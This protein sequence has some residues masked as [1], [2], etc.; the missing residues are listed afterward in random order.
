M[1]ASALM[2]VGTRALVASQA[3]LQTTSHNISNAGVDGYSRQ[4]VLL[5]TTTGVYSGAGFIGRGVTVETVTRAVSSYL[6]D[7]AAHTSSVAS[8]DQ[9]T[10][11]L[12]GQLQDAFGTGEAGL[13]YATT[14]LLNAFSDLSTTPG[15]LSARQ[16]VLS[17]A[18]DLASLFS[19]TSDQVESLQRSVNDDVSSGAGT[20]NSL[21]KQVAALNDKIANFRGTGH[22]PNDLLDQRDQLISQ[23]SQYVEVSRLQQDD[24]AINLF[25]AGGQSLVLGNQSYTLSATPDPYDGSRVQLSIEVAG[26]VRNLDPD[27]LGGGSLASQLK[28]QRDDLASMRAQLGQLAATL[29]GAVNERQS[30]GLDLTGSTGGALF[31][32]GTSTT[33]PTMAMPASGNAKDSSGNFVGS[34]SLAV[35]DRT[36]LEASDYELRED[37]SAAG[38]YTLTRLSDGAVTTGVTDGSTVD[39]FTITFGSPG[40]QSGDKFLLKP[41]ST[42]ASLMAVNQSD[43]RSL[44]AANPVT[45]TASAS[46]RGTGAIASLTITAAPASSYQAMSLVFTSPSGDYELRDSG[47]A[48]LTSG[49]WSAARAITYDGIELTLNGAPASGDTFSIDP[50]ADVKTSN[51]NALAFVGLAQEA[52]VGDATFTDAFANMLSDLGVRVQSATAAAETSASTA[53]HVQ[54]SLSADTGVNLDEEAAKLIQYQQGYQAAAKILSVAQKVFD[55]LLSLGG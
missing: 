23:I 50:T 28:F 2:N 18:Q 22:D 29:G 37:P 54:Q 53:S 3:Q 38:T 52:M 6:T 14:Q 48:V 51:G 8:G 1:S 21:A 25:V 36:A 11:T 49:T 46:N 35:T 7:L 17:R 12:L 45:A 41:V 33:L 55:T 34:M 44:A 39:G 31:K 26:E 43:P 4:S 16:V 19:S 30:L 32:F 10:S 24:G 42:A 27:A 13:G 5:Q 9:Q 15:D 20:V 47:G 40:P